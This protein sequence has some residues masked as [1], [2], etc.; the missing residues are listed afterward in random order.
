MNENLLFEHRNI[1]INAK[2]I[3]GYSIYLNLPSRVCFTT[4]KF[5]ETLLKHTIAPY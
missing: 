4:N 1:V 2:H 3:H 5:K